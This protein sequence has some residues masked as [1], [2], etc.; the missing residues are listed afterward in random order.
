METY[1]S[2]K[3]IDNQKNEDIKSLQKT[4]KK[5]LNIWGRGY[6]PK[7]N[8]EDTIGSL[9]YLECQKVLEETKS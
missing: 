2:Q 9:L 6:E 5:C 4:L 3:Q 8:V 7:E 1:K